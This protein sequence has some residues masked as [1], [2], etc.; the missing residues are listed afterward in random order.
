MFQGFFK[1]TQAFTA[2]LTPVQTL[3]VK[4]LLG[5]VDVHVGSGVSDFSSD[6]VHSIKERITRN[7]L[8][9]TNGECG[10]ETNVFVPTR[11]EVGLLLR[12]ELTTKASRRRRRRRSPLEHRWGDE[13][14]LVKLRGATDRTQQAC[15]R[16][17]SWEKEAW[18]GTQAVSLDTQHS[19][20][21]SDG[22]YEKEVLETGKEKT[23]F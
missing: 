7:F 22:C 17:T 6:R 3:S 13:V 8:G 18:D 19:W 23:C 10:S 21:T 14:N 5:F 16:F 20:A 4:T 11:S 2:A 1:N 9:H 12:R 15:G